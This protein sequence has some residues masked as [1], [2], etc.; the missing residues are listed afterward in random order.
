MVI[1]QGDIKE[2]EMY[3]G[4]SC[5]PVQDEINLNLWIHNSFDGREAYETGERKVH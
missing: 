4:C 5:R 3:P 2:H 1:P